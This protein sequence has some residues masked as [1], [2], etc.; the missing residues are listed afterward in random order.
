MVGILVLHSQQVL[1]TALLILLVLL[2][3]RELF[4]LRSAFLPVFWIRIHLLR[5]RIRILIKHFTFWLNCD[6]DPDPIRIQGFDDQKLKK[7]PTEKKIKYFFLSKTTI[8]L[9]LILVDKYYSS[10]ADPDPVASETFC[11]IRSRIRKKSFRSGQPGVIGALVDRYYSSVADP[12]P[13]SDPVLNDLQCVFSACLWRG[14]CPVWRTG[15]RCHSSCS[16]LSSSSP[17][18]QR[19]VDEVVL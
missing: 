17:L 2:A 4:Q 1:H 8:Y 10:V 3:L 16:P 15:W 9:S 14:T 12:D 13:E 5:I 7:F 18:A 19:Q 6:L 11:Y